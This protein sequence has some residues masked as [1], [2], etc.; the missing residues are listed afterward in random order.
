MPEERV[1]QGI[2]RR[3]FLKE[4]AG[5]AAAFAAGAGV[6][7]SG[8]AVAANE[9]VIVGVM[10]VRGRGSGLAAGFAGMPDV[11]V[12]YVCDVDE[13]LLPPRASTVAET[14]GRSPEQVTDFRRI[15]ENKAVDA[16][17]V[18]APD[19]WHALATI[20]A[21]QAGKDVYVEKPASHNIR[22]G[23]K[24]IEAARR[25]ERVV[26]VGTQSRSG[27]HFHSAIEFLRSGKLGKIIMAK[28]INNQ[29][30]AN[31]G[32]A[33]DG[34][35]PPGVHYDMWLGPAPKRPFNR[36]RFHYNWHWFWEYGT[37]DL[38]ND[39]VHQV[40]V[41]RWGLGVEQPTAV[42]CSGGKF[43]FDDDQQTPDT[44]IVT[45][46]YPECQLVYEMRLWAPYS[47]SGF[48]NGNIFFG[49]KGYMV[50]GAGGWK[51]VWEGD[52][53]GPESGA[54]DRDDAHRRNFI[55]CI[56][57]RTPEKLN[58][59]IREGHLSAMLCHLGNISYRVGRRLPFDADTESFGR[60][61]EA[62]GYLTRE[63]RSPWV[64][65]EEV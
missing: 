57:A 2:N 12:A 58:A 32:H 41:A 45:W 9:K 17:V 22:E 52:E 6:V 46:E 59:E 20:R 16:L 4:S 26:Q 10:G 23:R 43:H 28:A 21:C 31:I 3:G 37:G 14:Q 19:H 48:S 5:R 62:N 55:D 34:P 30:R 7:T 42:S 39:G 15:L 50:L 35:V 24:M 61:D 54:S 63:Y 65:P 36:N 51:V 44:Q 38:G 33:E 25:Y 8:R 1:M 29:K 49:E 47:Q 53:P 64:V 11:E 27:A 18:A 56:K 60:D 13:S 40:D